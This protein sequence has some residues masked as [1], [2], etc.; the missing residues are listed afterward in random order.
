MGGVRRGDTANV[1]LGMALMNQKK[2]ELAVD[3]FRVALKDKRSTGAARKWIAYVQ[4]EIRR[5]N[6]LEQE[7]P[8]MKRR[9]QD[10]I[11]RANIPQ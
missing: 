7:L 4:G 10:E 6:T 2:Y 9:E 11:L 1:M 3:A 5:R 8:T